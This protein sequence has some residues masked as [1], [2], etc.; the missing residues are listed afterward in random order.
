M[1]PPTQG[2]CA[3]TPAWGGRQS[4]DQSPK[5]APQRP[6]RLRAR[7]AIRAKILGV[8]TTLLFPVVA[9]GQSPLPAPP[10]SPAEARRLLRPPR[11]SLS[12]G[13]TNAGELRQGVALP[14]AGPGYR[15]LPA[16]LPRKTTYG[17]SGLV[18]LIQRVGIRVHARFPHARMGV[19]NLS[20]EG[21]G[22]TGG[23]VSHKTG[24][25]VDLG[26]F[27]LSKSGRPRSLSSFVAFE[28]DGWDKRHRYRFDE[29]ANL[30]L[31][32]ALV[33]DV[34]TPV[35]V[36]FVADWLK[37]R[38]LSEARRR[39][40]PGEMVERLGVVLRQPSDSNPHHHHFHVRVYCS[41]QERLHGCLERGDI[42]PWVDLGD[43]LF[44]AR[45]A[46]LQQLLRMESPTW[47]ARGAKAL[48]DL[49]A[50]GAMEALLGRC[51]DP[52]KR[53]RVAALDALGRIASLDAFPA[54]RRRLSQAES[55]VA[56]A[57]ILPA[58]TRLETPELEAVA[59]NALSR[60]ESLEGTAKT[61]RSARLRALDVLARFG[62]GASVLPLLLEIGG[63][64][65]KVSQRAHQVL[66]RVTLQRVRGHGRTPRAR[67]ALRKRWEAFFEKH[68]REAWTQW[69][70]RGFSA[71]GLTWSK[72]AP[73]SSLLPKLTHRD[74][75]VA[76]Q[77][78]FL[79]MEATGHVAYPW[80]RSKNN[81]RRH[82]TTWLRKHPP[83]LNSK[84]DTATP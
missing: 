82:W 59:L 3:S 47:R 18:G 26:M 25:D 21:G 36:I 31:V 35:Q 80:W 72:G 19:G 68:G 20:R 64:D 44:R 30:E 34:E 14:P 1:A 8:V 9:L 55:A 15:V 5:S 13:F 24:R 60:I 78:A 38:L 22:Q 76:H 56:V 29:A 43:E 37:D 40:V 67:R 45:V 46:K 83:S 52:S 42:H 69:M 74:D 53:V 73:L 17:T 27:A 58:I 39:G 61:R 66:R 79:L 70:Q 41:L 54:L 12:L 32:L 77:A 63:T 11:Q 6:P 48:G 10:P 75:D 33:G 16:F 84:R 51:A 49:R 65:R 57:E 2:R 62:R 81:N 23:S 7:A 50:R 71:R 28:R 4:G